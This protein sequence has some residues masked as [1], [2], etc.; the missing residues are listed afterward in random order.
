MI[1]FFSLKEANETP[2]VPP[3]TK[4]A[5]KRNKE[6]RREKVQNRAPASKP[7]AVNQYQ[8]HL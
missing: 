1:G 2:D 8:F 4:E 7:E 6:S 3:G 5:N